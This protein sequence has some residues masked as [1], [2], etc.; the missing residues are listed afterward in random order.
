[1]AWMGEPSDCLGRTKTV[2]DVK[3]RMLGT[4]KASGRGQKHALNS[5]GEFVT[6]LEATVR[7]VGK[8]KGGQDSRCGDYY[9]CNL[10]LLIYIV[11]D[12]RHDIPPGPRNSSPGPTEQRHAAISAFLRHF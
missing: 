5:S 12:T 9:V 4:R 2:D 10:R 1:M 7:N 6:R 8:Q 11:L 3:T